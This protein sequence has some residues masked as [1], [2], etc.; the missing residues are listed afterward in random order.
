LEELLP[1][2][3]FAHGRSPCLRVYPR[4]ISD[5]GSSAEGCGTDDPAA[6]RPRH[7]GADPRMPRWR[8]AP[9]P[10]GPAE[11]AGEPETIRRAANSPIITQG[12]FVFAEVIVGMIDASAI[13]RPSTPWTRRSASTTASRPEPI[14]QVPTGWK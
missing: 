8:S 1:G 6:P 14:A 7:L 5:P 12:A 2:L 11:S 3:H 9:R 10:G 4:E 13:R